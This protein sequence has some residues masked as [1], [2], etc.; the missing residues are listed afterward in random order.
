[1]EH[2]GELLKRP[3]PQNPPDIPPAYRELPIDC[4]APT[5]DDICRAIKQLNNNKAVGPDGIP[6]EAAL[7]ADTY[8][9][10]EM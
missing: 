10:V 5:K 2:F 4:N 3:S 1:M 8:T 7:K 9:R 6:A